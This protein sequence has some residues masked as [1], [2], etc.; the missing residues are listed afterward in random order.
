M[1]YS[2]GGVARGHPAAR[3]NMIH[4]EPDVTIPAGAVT[5]AD[6]YRELIGMRVD[7][8]RALTK[9]D[10]AALVDSDH[11]QRLR[12]LERFRFTLLGAAVAASAV[13]S[14]LGAWIA[15]GVQPH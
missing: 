8:A 12:A 11:E 10:A 2:V 3:P 15:S 6:L 7:V 1:L 9:L 4:M 5:T 14:A 13:F